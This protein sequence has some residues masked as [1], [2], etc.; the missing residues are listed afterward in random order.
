MRKRVVLITGAS[1]GI[2]KETANQLIKGGYI[3]YGAA[4]GLM[5]LFEIYISNIL[6]SREGL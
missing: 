5:L 4:R 2:G 1:S 6:I 3:V